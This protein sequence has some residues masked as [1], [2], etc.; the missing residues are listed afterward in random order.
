MKLTSPI[1][2]AFSEAA[3]RLQESQ[4]HLAS[5][6]YQREVE[7]GRDIKGQRPKIKSF[8]HLFD[9]GRSLYIYA[10]GQTTPQIHSDMYQQLAVW[11]MFIFTIL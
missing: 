6:V 5:T 10:M 9:Q 1:T 7:V 3:Y 11:H 8:R 4:K 2:S